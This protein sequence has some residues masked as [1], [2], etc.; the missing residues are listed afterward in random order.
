MK[1][2][3]IKL[4]SKL[5]RVV[6]NPISSFRS[7]RQLESTIVRKNTGKKLIL[8]FKEEIGEDELGID[9]FLS[10]KKAYQSTLAVTKVKLKHAKEDY[11]FYRKEA[12]ALVRRILECKR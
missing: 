4:G 8:D 9:W 10:K 3:K 2:S 7:R 6:Y 11:D 1:F 5:Y 12:D